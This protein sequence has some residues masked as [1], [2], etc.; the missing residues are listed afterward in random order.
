MMIPESETVTAILDAAECLVRNG[1]SAALDHGEIAKLAGVDP[2]Q[3]REL[4]PDLGY[5][6]ASVVHR[7][8][9]TTLAALGT[10]DDGHARP[11]D[12]LDWLLRMLRRTLGEDGRMCPCAALAGESATL[13][14]AV[15][16]EVRR[17]FERIEGWIAR[18]IGEGVPGG[19]GPEARARALRLQATL[20][21]AMLLARLER[22][23]TV[24]EQITSGL[25]RDVLRVPPR[26]YGNA[27]AER[28]WP[29]RRGIPEELPAIW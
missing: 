25:V 27:D 6:A 16:A 13:P 29:S 23:P 3:V 12:R 22:D 1:G 11:S 28:P 18:V 17:Y 15:A 14:E 9:E 8:T 20:Q 7:Y 24:F 21:G 2:A 4:F 5:I 19:S 10:I 26:S